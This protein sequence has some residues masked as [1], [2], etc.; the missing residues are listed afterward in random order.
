MRIAVLGLG[1]MG[2]AVA[3]RLLETG[4]DVAIWNRTPGKGD[5][6]IARGAQ[7][8]DSVGAAAAGSEVTLSVLAADPAV[9]EV[10][11]GL[12]GAI[13]SAGPNAVLVDMSTVSPD[14][15]RALAAEVSGDRFL[16]APIMGSPIATERG[17][18]R[19]LLS[20]PEATARRLD[21]L[22]SD[23]AAGYVYCGPTGSALTVKLMSNEVLIGSTLLLAQA[24]VTAQRNGI[25]DDVIRQVFGQS[26]VVGPGVLARFES[27]M[28]DEHPALW[29]IDLASKD[30]RLALDLA[31]R[32]GVSAPVGAATG[33]E[34]DRAAQAGLGDA[35]MAAVVDLLRGQTAQNSAS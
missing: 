8:M 17:Q 20:G 18:A 31:E 11:F 19:L 25:G 10:Y 15:A 6:L 34:L 1:R 22:W 21:P 16:E 5:D 33:A 7:E 3:S 2:H 29:S 26:L 12:T 23:L 24:I 35:D 28:S 13:A 32:A 9:R 14:T 4:H 27:L 30:I